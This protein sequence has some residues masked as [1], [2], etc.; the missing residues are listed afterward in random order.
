[1][2]III[3]KLAII[4]LSLFIVCLSFVFLLFFDL[5]E[6]AFLYN[7]YINSVIVSSFII[8]LIISIIKII[9]YE[10]EYKK[11]NNFDNLSKRELNSLRLL[12]PINLYI[13]KNNKMLSQ[14]KL[15]TLLSS[16][17]KKVEESEH[18]TKY[19]S[20]TLIFLGLFG[21]FWGLSQTIGNVS[22]II[23]NL[24]IEQDASASFLKLKNS[25]KIPLEGMGIAFGC[26]LFGLFGSLILSFV[27]MIQKKIS[28]KFLDKVEEWL[29][30]HSIKLEIS[31]NNKNY[32]GQLFSMNLLEK[33]IETIYAFQHQ[34][35]DL[36]ENRISLYTMQKEIGQK[37]ADLS[38]SIS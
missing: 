30:K 3:S 25:L 12:A 22:S 13:N 31:E 4:Q 16:I 1:M 15:Q 9:S 20:G 29:S 26:S 28:D 37:I 21:T 10:L 5:F 11:L 2:L 38:V 6:K 23:D 36:S 32:N 17:E 34:L 24:G 27:V 14:I 33:T 35:N 18:I 8:G 7:I 19:L